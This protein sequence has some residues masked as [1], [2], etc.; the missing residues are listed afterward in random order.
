[1]RSP[2]RRLVLV[3]SPLLGPAVW[4]PVAERLRAEGHRVTVPGGGGVVRSPGDVVRD[5]LADLQ[6][7]DPL[8]LVPH[9]NAGLYV[10]ALAAA[11]PV[12]AVVFVDAGLPSAAETTPA[13][14]PGFRQQ[15]GALVAEDGLLPPWSSWWPGEDTDALFPDEGSRAAVEREQRRL[16]LSYFGADVATPSGWERLPAAYLAF[17]D[18]YSDERSE[19]QRRGW[20]TETLPGRH[21]HQLV[22]PAGVA[23][24]VLRLL[25][26]AHGD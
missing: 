24:A 10:A 1:M 25:R 21:L 8:T 4:A 13:A 15:L 26:A 5:L 11:R 3:A 12:E 16:P 18:T 23:E 14:P 19:A 9:S 6:A 17:G 2:G 20:P 22:D 7:D